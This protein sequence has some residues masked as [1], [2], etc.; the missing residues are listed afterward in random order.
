MLVLSRKEGDK[1]IINDDITVTVLSV[2]KDHVRLGF[3]A[4]RSVPVYRE[5]VYRTIVQA[6]AEAATPTGSLEALRNRFGRKG[7]AEA[8]Q[9]SEA[10]TPAA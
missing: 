3:E 4:P 8:A 5:E 7:A 9:A 2:T 6:N 1:V 10:T